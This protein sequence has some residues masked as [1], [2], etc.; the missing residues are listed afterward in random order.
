MS[1]KLNLT[2]TDLWSLYDHLDE[3]G[4]NRISVQAYLRA[5]EAANEGGDPYEAVMSRP[6]SRWPDGHRPSTTGE[7]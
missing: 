2:L 1:D 7:T 4:S 6:R 3:L 5:V